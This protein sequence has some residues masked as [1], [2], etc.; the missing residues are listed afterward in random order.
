MKICILGTPISSGNRG[1]LALASALVELVCEVNSSAEISL[2]IGHRSSFVADFETS[3]GLKRVQVVNFRLSP[4]SRFVEHL[5]AIILCCLVYR[6]FPLKALKRFLARK[7]PFIGEVTSSDVVGNI[8]GGDSFSDIYGLGRFLSNCAVDACIILLGA[9]LVQLPQT[10]GPFK[11]KT[12][13]IAAAA[14][15]R[16]S[17]IVMARDQDSFDLAAGILGAHS[18]PILSPDVA[19]GLSAAR[20]FVPKTVPPLPAD[21][22]SVRYIGI[23]VN[24]L[25]LNG[26]YTRR[27]MFGLKLDYRAYLIEVITLLAKRFEGEFWFIPHTYGDRD[28]V[29]S[30]LLASEVLVAGLPPE[31]QARTRVV[32]HAYSQHELKSIIGCSEFFIGGRMHACIAA[33][34]QSVPCAGVAYS[35]KFHGVFSTVGAEGCILEAR[36][37]DISQAIIRTLDAFDHRELISAQL[38][39]LMP[40]TR[41]RLTEVFQ[42]LSMGHNQSMQ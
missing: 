23:N 26:G 5:A 34:S 38:R 41:R 19:F 28:T 4:R 25:V 12:A 9:P 8:H 17:S 15:L 40:S 22:A 20:Q 33:L 11:T 39:E 37:L 27:N 6:I 35:K 2:L 18:R 30:D 13:R 7:I 1:V 21:C 29:E 31:V 16:H 32:K 10:Y 14:I 42:S 3:A 24:G 36:E